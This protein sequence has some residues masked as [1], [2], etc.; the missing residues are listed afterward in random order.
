[1]RRVAVRP[2]SPHHFQHLMAPNESEVEMECH[3]LLGGAFGGLC[4]SKLKLQHGWTLFFKNTRLKI[5]LGA[6]ERL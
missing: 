4:P 5:C 2:K 1:M 6:K 3:R